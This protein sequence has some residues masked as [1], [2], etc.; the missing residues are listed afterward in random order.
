M[1]DCFTYRERFTLSGEHRQ[2]I[3]SEGA[4]LSIA[5]VVSILNDQAGALAEAEARI[6]AV[7]EVCD[8]MERDGWGLALIE[9]VRAALTG[10]AD[11]E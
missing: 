5:Y 7:R 3:E 4:K 9:K 1:S 11:D 10:E 6:E 2:W 8:E